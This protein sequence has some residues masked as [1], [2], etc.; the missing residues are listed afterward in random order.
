[1]PREGAAD[2]P[3]PDAS[4]VGT[5]VPGD[6]A[7]DGPQSPSITLQKFAP[8]EIQIGKPAQF[9]V[10]IRNVGQSP[11]EKVIVRD[12]VPK[13]TQLIDTT[14]AA[15]ETNGT[16]IVWDV[17]TIQPN[18]EKTVVMQVMPM[19]EGEVGSV[20]NVTFAAQASVRTRATRP[21]LVIEHTVPQKVM[22][23]SPVTFSI[24]IS[25]PG[26]GAA[27]GVV[28]EENVPEGLSH[29]A[30]TELE[31]EVGTLKPGETR[32]LE[33]T[34]QAK[35][36]GVVENVLVCRGDANLVAEDR[37]TLEVIAPQL[38]LALDGPSR[39][40]LERPATFEITIANPGTA[41]AADVEMM[42]FLPK[43]MKF[44]ETNNA[45]VYDAERNA[46]FW[47]VA[48]L[49]AGGSG[50][51]K[52]VVMPLEAGEQKIRIEGRAEPGLVDMFEHT[53]MV[54]GLA[55]LFF[56]LSDSADPIE[57]GEETFYEIR[58]VNQ[59]SKSSEN[60]QV[61]AILPPEMKPLGG[62]GAARGVVEGQTIKFEPM[63][64][65]APKADATYKVRAQAIA[66]GDHR[67][68]VQIL[69]A[70]MQQPVTREESTLVY[71]D[72]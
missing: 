35:S 3:N 29:P 26:T 23:G 28:L 58:L 70:E 47:S 11:A 65:L 51:V 8:N 13:G 9:A 59:G 43:G 20:A 37:S 6:V 17:G 30:G 50:T 4:P 41:L 55:S 19:E 5:G 21:E 27:T 34:L 63:A 54:E 25:N 1:M 52:L 68:R 66:A 56:E 38:K 18:E 71:S 24:K 45:G 42:A 44:K 61:Q 7:L 64:R 46:V 10:K 14:P 40:F 57:V 62:D 72:Q 16:E 32:Q 12:E 2:P 48:E 67:I 39:R 31:F 22:A 15:I 49:P 69:S 53:V 33:L 60:I 36:A